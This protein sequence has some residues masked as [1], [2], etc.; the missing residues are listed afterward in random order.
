MEYQKYDKRINAY[1]KLIGKLDKTV[2]IFSR[3]RLIIFLMLILGGILCF[4]KKQPTLF[5][6]DLLIFT[7]LFCIAVYFHNKY[8]N[9]R[10][11]VLALKEINEINKKRIQGDFKE[12]K[13][14]GTE[15]MKEG[16]PYES[17]LDIFGKGSLYQFLAMPMTPKGR[18]RLSRALKD[19]EEFDV[20]YILKKQEAVKELSK[21]TVFR[22]R[23][24]GKSLVYN[25]KLIDYKKLIDIITSPCE[26]LVSFGKVL[27]SVISGATVVSIILAAFKLI[28]YFVPEI[29]IIL[30]VIILQ[31]NKKER[32]EA[33][34][35]VG[36]QNKSLYAYKEILRLI[37]RRNY[38]SE[39]LKETKESLTKNNKSSY[40]S[41]DELYNIAEKLKN[42]QNGFYIILNM[43]FLLDY[44]YYIKLNN[45]KKSYSENIEAI[46]ESIALFEELSCYSMLLKDMKGYTIPVFSNN[47]EIDAQ[48]IAHPLLVNKGISNYITLNNNERMWMITGSN[49]SGKSTYLRTIGI[50]LVLAYAGAPVKSSKFICNKMN[51]YT[52]MRTGDDLEKS[53]SSFYAEI[54]KVKRIVS[55]TN[56]KERVFFL[57]DEIFKGT[58]SKDRHKGA[59]ILI[60]QLI[61][62][63]TLGLVSTHDLELG[64]MENENSFIR[65]YNF[66]EYFENNEINF[67]YKLRKGVSETQNALYLMKL[68]GIEI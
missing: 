23:L 9:K 49:M 55:A 36:E 67:D 38:S 29:L 52:C 14:L 48:N 24:H 39:L 42:R 68:A 4:I 19:E 61:N 2:S 37:E 33:F 60:N 50:N 58:N 20:K 45:W 22:E 8:L 35:L 28:P 62:K 12:F 27:I 13:D 41:M 47:R 6:I 11:E 59:E 21:T 25:D 30:N 34:H 63:D 44:H 10:Q 40:K 7:V 3:I 15:F 16:H 53:I 56:N 31:L 32:L 26:N 43:I 18:E 1:E 64:D 57:L 66:R 51:I 65:N 46:I 54:L 5:V 17:D